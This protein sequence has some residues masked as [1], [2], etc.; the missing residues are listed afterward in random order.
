MIKGSQLPFFP[1]YLHEYLGMVTGA[2]TNSPN[3]H[4]MTSAIVGTVSKVQLWTHIY[5]STY[6]I[7]EDKENQ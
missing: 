7:P 2:L 3:P 4:Q 1:K 5:S 6:F